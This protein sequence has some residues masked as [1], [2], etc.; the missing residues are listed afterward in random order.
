MI[1]IKIKFKIIGAAAATPNLLCE[2][3]IAEKNDA[4][5]IKSKKGKVIRVN[6]V[7]NSNLL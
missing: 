3:S 5:L 6:K 2:F 7:V 1:N 4:K